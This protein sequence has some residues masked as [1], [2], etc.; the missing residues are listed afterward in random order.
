[1]VRLLWRLPDPGGF[2]PA[3][4]KIVVVVAAVPAAPFVAIGAAVGP[5]VVEA[6]AETVQ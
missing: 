2:R 5:A 6:A 3:K 1:M 4:K